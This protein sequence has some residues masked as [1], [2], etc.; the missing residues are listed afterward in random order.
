METQYVLKH[1]VEGRD[2]ICRFPK[3]FVYVSADK[4]IFSCT[5]DHTYDLKQGLSRITFQ[6]NSTWIMLPEQKNATYA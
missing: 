6:A 2:W 5:Y 4:K 1:F 3:M